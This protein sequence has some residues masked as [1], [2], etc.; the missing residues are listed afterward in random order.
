VSLAPV[1]RGDGARAIA[2]PLGI[3]AVGIES[4]FF[5]DGEGCA[6]RRLR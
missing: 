6:A 5:D 4:G 1:Q 2:P 3:D